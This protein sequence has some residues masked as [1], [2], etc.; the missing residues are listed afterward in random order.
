M[1]FTP[2]ILSHHYSWQN[3]GSVSPVVQTRA[4]FLPDSPAGMLKIIEALE[5]EDR[6]TLGELIEDG[7]NF[8]FRVQYKDLPDYLKIFPDAPS[9]SKKRISLITLTCL[10]NNNESL[11]FLLNHE[12]LKQGLLEISD[13]KG[14]VAPP[15]F[16][17]I[18]K[19]NITA[20]SL[21]ISA[22]GPDILISNKFNG[23]SV[24]DFCVTKC[25]AEKELIEYMLTV[26][27]EN[28]D[29]DSVDTMITKT[30]QYINQYMDY[31]HD[32]LTYEKI[33]YT[34]AD[35]T[36]PDTNLTLRECSTRIKS[37]VKERRMMQLIGGIYYRDE[38]EKGLPQ[39]KNSTLLGRDI[40]KE[41]S[42]R[43]SDT[44]ENQPSTHLTKFDNGNF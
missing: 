27:Y 18:L 31:H 23:K 8:E 2:K 13:F 21:L 14:E 26:L 37:T 19:N 33:D 35:I 38:P 7:L 22:F 5:S 30:Y 29:D 34:L 40:F 36:I 9:N 43:L 28:M 12:T 17:S 10:I 39:F 42:A 6:K 16:A 1:V 25:K 11:A 4:K 24:L 32:F 44:I 41:I 20:V 15:L 3:R